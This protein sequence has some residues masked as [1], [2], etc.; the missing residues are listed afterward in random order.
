VRAIRAVVR[1]RLPDPSTAYD[2]A[3]RLSALAPPDLLALLVYPPE[4][5]NDDIDWASYPALWPRA[6][7]AW[8]CLGLL[9]HKA[10]QPWPTSTRR[11]VLADLVFGVEDWTTEAAM[12]ALSVAAWVDP[13]CRGDVAALVRERLSAL[14]E[15]TRHRP[16]TIAASLA[17]IALNTPDVGPQARE[18]ARLLDRSD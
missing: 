11:Q 17:R 4:Q 12:F 1:F 7:Q 16:V 15:A 5:P 2:D 10:E 6:V 14:P 8:A 18:L 3:V 13:S 9:H